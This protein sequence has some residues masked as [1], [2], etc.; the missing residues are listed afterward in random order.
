LQDPPQVTQIRIFGLK[1]NHL[2]TLPLLSEKTF[3][4]LKKSSHET[5]I[6]CIVQEPHH[7]CCFCF[8]V[9]CRPKLFFFFVFKSGYHF[10][11]FPACWAAINDQSRECTQNNKTSLCLS[12]P[13]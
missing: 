6:I 8:F 2:A 12:A 9:F 13:G 7:I 10:L 3:D 1:I 5:V 4:T 11:L